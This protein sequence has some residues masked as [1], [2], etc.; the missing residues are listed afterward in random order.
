MNVVSNTSWKRCLLAV[1]HLERHISSLDPL[2]RWREHAR[3][4][5]RGKTRIPFV[6]SPCVMS[7][8]VLRR[9]VFINLPR[10]SEQEQKHSFINK[11]SINVDQLQQWIESDESIRNVRLRFLSCCGNLF[12]N[13]RYSVGTQLLRATSSLGASSAAH[14]NGKGPPGPSL[15]FSI[16]ER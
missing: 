13:W 6:R 4:N 10:R 1:F 11:L 2:L 16:S 14:K 5:I 8:F 12:F 3:R 7:L 9:C 15:R